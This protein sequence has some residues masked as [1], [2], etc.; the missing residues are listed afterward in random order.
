MKK[1]LQ[2]LGGI[3]V[4]VYVV[5]IVIVTTLLL[6]YNQYK[7][8][9]FNNKSLIII[10]EKSA[11][12]QNGDL[13]IFTK[14]NNDLVKINDEVFFYDVSNGEV[15]IN[16]GVVTKKD[17]IND[18]ETTFTINGSHELSS[19]MLIGKCSDAKIYSKLGAILRVLESKFGYLLIVILPTLILFLYEIYR[20]II[21][22]KTPVTVK[23]E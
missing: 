16:L 17:K 1:V 22:I 18:T 20:V 11:K 14:P 5:I 13:A 3:I 21:E 8:T 10:N 7:V 6:G 4:V 9:Q 2:I 12:Y 23:E 15:T 19:S